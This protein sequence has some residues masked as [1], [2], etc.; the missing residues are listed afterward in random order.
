MPVEAAR[1]TLSE[2]ILSLTPN[3]VLLEL[4]DNDGVGDGNE[5]GLGKNNCGLNYKL[6]NTFLGQVGNG[7]GNTADFGLKN[8]LRMIAE[9]K[10]RVNKKA[11]SRIMGTHTKGALYNGLIEKSPFL[12]N[13]SGFL[14]PI[15]ELEE[16]K[17]R[18]L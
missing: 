16:G 6:E 9:W 8:S 18:R 13:V 14:L 12:L 1:D 17:P 2:P 7:F 15:L 3:G 11:T 5:T 10:N 4:T